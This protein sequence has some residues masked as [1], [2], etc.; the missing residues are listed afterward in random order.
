MPFLRNYK[1]LASI[2]YIISALF[3]FSC[4]VYKNVEFKGVE[5]VKV[6]EFSKKGID[7]DLKVK[8]FNPNTYN[9][10]IDE[11]DLDFYIAGTKV[12]KAQIEA[13]KLKKKTE[14]S[15]DI[16]L[17]AAPDQLKLG[18]STMM[19]IL[20]SGKATVGVKGELKAKALVV[21]KVIPVNFEQTIGL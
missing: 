17:K 10:K 1:S 7:V 20:F 21:S 3:L 12:G 11:S 16:S 9:I 2:L 5:D 18:L 19:S 6:N 13:I 15:Y 8:I 4:Q 14:Q